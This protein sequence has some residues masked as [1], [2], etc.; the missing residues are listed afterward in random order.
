MLLSLLLKLLLRIFNLGSYLLLRGYDR[1]TVKVFRYLVV[2][3]LRRSSL[4]DIL[5]DSLVD[6]LGIFGYGSNIVLYPEVSTKDIVS[7]YRSYVIGS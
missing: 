1:H 5:V 6:N 7:S 2:H 4:V 3:I